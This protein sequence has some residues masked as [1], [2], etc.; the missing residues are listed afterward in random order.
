[1]SQQHQALF[2]LLQQAIQLQQLR[3]IDLQFCQWLQQQ[4][5]QS[6][7]SQLFLSALVSAALAEGHVCID[8]RDLEAIIERWPVPIRSTAIQLLPTATEHGLLVDQQIIGDGNGLTPLVI[9]NQRLY[10]YRYWQ[11]ECKVANRLLSAN[12][13]LVTPI[14]SHLLKEQLDRYFTSSEQPDWQRIAA[15]VTTNH[16]MTVISG[17]PGTGKTTTVTKLLAIYIENQLAIG[18]RP[19]IQL[20]APTGKA[21]ARLS[22]SIAQAKN[23]LPI[24]EQVLSLI[25]EQGK[26]IH[27]LLGARAKS[28]K[29]IHNSDNPLLV[30]LLVIDE[31]SMIDL[32]MMANIMDA[33]SSQTRLILIGDRDQLAS[34]E[35]GSVLGDICALPKIACYSKQLSALLATSC[36]YQADSSTGYPFADHLAFLKKSYRFSVDSGIGELARVCNAGDV[37]GVERVLQTPFN[38]L[39]WLGADADEKQLLKQILQGYSDYIALM[40]D[41]L[42]PT[43]LLAGFNRFQ[44]LCALRVGPFGVESINQQLEHYFEKQQLKDLE[45]RWYVGRPVMI[46]RNDNQMQLYNGDIGIACK[47]PQNGQLKVWFEQGGELRALL[48]SRLPAHETVF[49]MTVHKS[50]GSEFNHVMLVLAQSAKVINRELIYTAITRAKEQ[51]SFLGVVKVLK[52]AVALTTK[53]S[54]GLADRIWRQ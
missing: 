29:F 25:P 3:A 18:H 43:E 21:A 34:V 1:M 53:R 54:S 15:A 16:L 51:F 31:A 20:A 37:E 6:S 14:A 50:Q 35:A 28:K 48:P 46:T 9:D 27:R 41:A 30:D 24:S 17:G 11:Y 8:L 39:N 19:I 38:D 2:A 23:N 4:L 40:K 45:N 52:Q 32:P 5:P 44:V 13:A 49:A 26:T 7:E 47:D 12:Q 42:S 36:D 22:E 33:L 10:L